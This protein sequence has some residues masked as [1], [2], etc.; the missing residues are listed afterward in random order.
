MKDDQNGNCCSI[1]QTDYPS[2][3]KKEY[4]PV[5]VLNNILIL[6]FQS[7]FIIAWLQKFQKRISG[8]FH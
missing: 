1:G 7:Q 8:K 2:K 4:I 5:V 3:N 6:S